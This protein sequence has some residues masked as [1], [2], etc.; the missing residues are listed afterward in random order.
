MHNILYFLALNHLIEKYLLFNIYSA[1]FKL[2]V[3]FALA[4]QKRTHTHTIIQMNAKTYGKKETNEKTIFV[5]KIQWCKSGCF[6]YLVRKYTR[7]HCA[8]HTI[9]AWIWF[10]FFIYLCIN[11]G[12]VSANI[13][14]STARFIQNFIY[15]ICILLSNARDIRS[16]VAYF[17][18]LHYCYKTY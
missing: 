16:T 1:N 4:K 11:V 10:L 13:M 2:F 9:H 14:N 5:D 18:C 3:T 15:F 17:C 8:A 7:V 6:I 12:S